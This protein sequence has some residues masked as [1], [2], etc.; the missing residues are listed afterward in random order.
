MSSTHAWSAYRYTIVSKFQRIGPTVYSA[1]KRRN[2]YI[3]VPDNYYAKRHNKGHVRTMP[4]GYVWCQIAAFP[5]KRRIYCRHCG[6]NRYG[7]ITFGKEENLRQRGAAS[8]DGAIN[9]PNG[10]SCAL[11]SSRFGWCSP[12]KVWKYDNHL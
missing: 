8:I 11:R 1:P 2:T 7:P 5:A 9:I 10:A 12:K 4:Y 3:S 6:S